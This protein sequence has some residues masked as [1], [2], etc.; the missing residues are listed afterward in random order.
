MTGEHGASSGR[1]CGTW[2]MKWLKGGKGMALGVALSAATAAAALA[3]QAPG[4]P[5]RGAFGAIETAM[6]PVEAADNVARLYEGLTGLQPQRP[7]VVDTYVLAASWWNDPVFESEAREAA[8]VLARRFDADGRTLVLSAGRGPGV[9]RAFPAATPNS[10][11]AALGRIGQI[12]DPAEDLVVVFL[13]SHG[14][15]DGAVAIQE[16]GRMGGA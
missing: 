8:A 12:I 7:G 1:C 15:Q 5:L 13:T 10:F 14:G 2:L 6:S 4:D 9:A 11:N 16:K 3:Q